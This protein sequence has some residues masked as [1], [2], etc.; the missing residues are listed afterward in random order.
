MQPTREFPG[1]EPFHD[2]SSTAAAR[3]VRIQAVSAKLAELSVL[4]TPTVRA[5]SIRLADE[6]VRLLVR[7][8]EYQRL[9]PVPEPD[10]HEAARKQLA[11][12][13]RECREPCEQSELSPLYNVGERLQGE[14]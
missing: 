10:T 9:L 13:L 14:A 11:E 5:R 3:L 7:E 6:L 8:E 1:E 2:G 12:A 4:N